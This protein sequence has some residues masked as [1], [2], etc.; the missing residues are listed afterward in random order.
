MPRQTALASRGR[1]ILLML[2]LV[3]LL[4]LLDG[5]FCQL[6]RFPPGQGTLIT[7]VG[8]WLGHGYTNLP[9]FLGLYL[10][11]RR[12][13]FSRLRAAAIQACWAFLLSGLLA[14]AVKH[15]VGRPRPRLYDD[16]LILLGPTLAKGFDSFSSGHTTT[17]VAVALIFSYHYPSGT[18]LF[19]GLAAFVAMSRLTCGSH[20][21]LDVL[22]GVLLG[23]FAGWAVIQY[24]ERGKTDTER[25]E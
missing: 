25:I 11:A 5:R 14:K 23:V 15:L 1:A 9:L 17:S 4:G 2:L 24:A 3:V 10:I 13:D 19:M 22:G 18:P 6:L 16:G 21:P 20:F 12:F 7:A 8:Y